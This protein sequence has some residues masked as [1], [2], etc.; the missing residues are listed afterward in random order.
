MDQFVV[1]G[2]VISLSVY[3]KYILSHV[4]RKFFVAIVCIHLD[5]LFYDLPSSLE[6]TRTIKNVFIQC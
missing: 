3:V 4:L 1:R 6:Q 5:A 2:G